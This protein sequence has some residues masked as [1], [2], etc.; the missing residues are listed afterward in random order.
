MSYYRNRS[1]HWRIRQSVSRLW[2]SSYQSHR[3]TLFI[4][5]SRL[6][7]FNLWYVL[8]YEYSNRTTRHTLC[9]IIK[10]LPTYF[11]IRSTFSKQIRKALYRTDFIIKK[12]ISLM[13][14][15]N[16]QKHLLLPKI[17]IK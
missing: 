16:W 15:E 5:W 12:R 3:S 11:S 9:C 17:R 2:K 6:C 14:P 8:L 1:L 4:C 10:S 13:V 7:I